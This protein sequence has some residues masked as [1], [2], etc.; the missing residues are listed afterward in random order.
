M[1]KILPSEITSYDLFKTLAV[2][3][4]IADHVGY[5]FFPED[6][7]WRVFGRMC[8][9]IWF[10]LVGYAQSRDMGLKMWAG[11]GI[12]IIANFITGMSIFPLNILASMLAVRMALDG[13]TKKFF[14]VENVFWP[15]V[16]IMFFLIVPT[17]LVVEY[18]TQGLILSVFGFIIRR[19]NEFNISKNLVD[20]YTI[21][22][23]LMF[24]IPQTVFFGF[25]QNQFMVMS[26]GVMVMMMALFFFQPRTFPRLTKFLPRP[27]VWFLHIG[28]RR[29]LEIYVLHLFLFKFMGAILEPDRFVWFDWKWLTMTGT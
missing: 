15:I 26:A 19:R 5:Y 9:P 1:K 3:L 22:A 28:G 25:T 29:T 8:V 21:A 4:M 27:F 24:V 17:M 23:F 18:G 20:K 12:L 7:W 14:E 16:L 11:A 6:N 13:V 2:A 10:F